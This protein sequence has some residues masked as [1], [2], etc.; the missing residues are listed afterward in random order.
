MLFR[1]ASFRGVHIGYR[2]NE[3]GIRTEGLLSVL[4]TVS[5][6]SASKELKIQNPLALTLSK[7]KYIY[8]L[9]KKIEENGVAKNFW[10]IVA[11]VSGLYLSRR[12]YIY[13]R[14]HP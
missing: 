4:G 12:M 7:N 2:D 13:H 6:D 1:D 14:K 8:L 3:F 9:E 10:L 5:Y 11:F